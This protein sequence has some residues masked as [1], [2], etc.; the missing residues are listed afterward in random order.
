M[1]FM[2]PVNS[3]YAIYAPPPHCPTVIVSCCSH[4]IA[5]CLLYSGTQEIMIQQVIR[6]SVQ[7]FF[8]LRSGLIL[9]LSEYFNFFLG[10][11]LHCPWFD[12]IILSYCLWSF[13][14]SWCYHYQNVSIKKVLSVRV[15]YHYVCI[16]SY[17]FTFK[18]NISVVF[19]RFISL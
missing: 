12:L 17:L 14:D 7:V 9:I 5:R 16:N 18:D 11:F 3:T 4:T 2:C 13:Y 10:I 19:L 8:H 15:C 1:L 6:L